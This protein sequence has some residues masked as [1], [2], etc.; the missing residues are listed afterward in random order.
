MI[1]GSVGDFGGFGNGC[2]T[3]WGNTRVTGGK[4][5]NLLGCVSFVNGLLEV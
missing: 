2:V 1:F 5:L 3:E 4:V